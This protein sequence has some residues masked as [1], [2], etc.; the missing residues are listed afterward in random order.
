MVHK[1]QTDAQHSIL[2]YAVLNP[3]K[4]PKEI[5]EDAEDDSINKEYVQRI[6]NDFTLPEDDW[7]F[8]NHD[9]DAEARPDVIVEGLLEDAEAQETRDTAGVSDD[10][11]PD[12][13]TV[14]DLE[15]LSYRGLQKLAKV[16]GL[17]ANL[18]TDEFVSRFKE[19]LD[20]NETQTEYRCPIC[21]SY[22][23]PLSSDVRRHISMSG[24]IHKGFDGDDY[25]EDDF[26]EVTVECPSDSDNGSTNTSMEFTEP[27]SENM[28]EALSVLFA[29]PDM[30]FKEVD[31]LVDMST[32]YTAQAVNRHYDLKK[33]NEN[34]RQ[35]VSALQSAL[36]VEP[37]D[38][39]AYDSNDSDSEA[40]TKGEDG[41]SD[42]NTTSMDDYIEVEEEYDVVEED[43][44]DYVEVGFGDL[45]A[46][47]TDRQLLEA[48]AVGANDIETSGSRSGQRTVVAPTMTSK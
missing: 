42:G 45:I 28:R 30:D 47:A 33:G 27:V 20:L 40:R 44:P 12:V 43:D 18:K 16:H 29:D 26:D 23:S 9:V 11:I 14:E 15:S 3:G 5:A 35:Q 24:D 36:D 2:R 32:G 8:E 25:T 17:P 10:D 41:E 21:D 38:L 34:Y 22:S 6:L 31:R 46:E 39:D 4:T 19:T 13:E 37:A 48:V 1:P 7:V